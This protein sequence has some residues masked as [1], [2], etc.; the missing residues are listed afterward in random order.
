MKLS[1]LD[2]ILENIRNKYNLE[3]LEETTL[4]LT[5]K[6]ILSGKIL[7]NESTMLVQDML[8]NQGIL[9]ETRQ[10]MGQLFQEA[11]VQGIKPNRSNRQVLEKINHTMRAN[12]PIGEPSDVTNAINK[13]KKEMHLKK[14]SKTLVPD[15]RAKKR[16]LNETGMI[17]GVSSAPA[18][19]GSSTPIAT[20]GNNRKQ[21]KNKY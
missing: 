7:I 2:L 15:R 20:Y 18:L 19:S 5:E 14:I 13:T 3:M 1:K 6:D 8:V 9:S 4:G 16:P 12:G 21:I 10:L 11:L 17:G